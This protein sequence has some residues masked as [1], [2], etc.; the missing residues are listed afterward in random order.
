MEQ[1]Q[2]LIDVPTT[3]YYIKIEPILDPNIQCHNIRLSLYCLLRIISY[4]YKQIFLEIISISVEE[5]H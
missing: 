4:V 1:F 2:E 3:T 5:K